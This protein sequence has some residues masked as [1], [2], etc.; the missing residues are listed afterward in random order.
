MYTRL[1]AG[2]KVKCLFTEKAQ[3]KTDW[4]TKTQ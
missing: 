3:I 1:D 4:E 2:A